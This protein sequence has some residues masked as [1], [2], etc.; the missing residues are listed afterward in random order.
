MQMWIKS[1]WESVHV[2]KNST[3]R[4]YQNRIRN[5]SSIHLGP[6]PLT[7]RPARSADE[8]YQQISAPQSQS[9]PIC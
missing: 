4:L 5:M 1:F 7:T 3:F 9:L 2:A 8:L 6:D